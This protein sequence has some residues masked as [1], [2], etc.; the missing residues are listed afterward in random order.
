MPSESSR[1]RGIAKRVH[2]SSW[3][4]SCR[5]P[6]A[7]RVSAAG[8]GVLRISASRYRRLRRNPGVGSGISVVSSGRSGWTSS[9]S[10]KNVASCSRTSSEAPIT[11]T[12]LPSAGVCCTA[13]TS[14]SSSRT[15]TC[16]PGAIS[17]SAADGVGIL[18]PS[19][20]VVREARSRLPRSEV[21]Q[22]V[23]FEERRQRVERVEEQG[24]TGER[25]RADRANGHERVLSAAD[26]ERGM[27]IAEQPIQVER[28]SRRAD[29][30]PQRL[31]LLADAQP[32]AEELDAELVEDVTVE[33]RQGL[34][35]EQ[36]AEPVLA[37]GA[38]GV[39][40]HPADAAGHLVL[41]AA[42][43]ARGQTVGFVDHDERVEA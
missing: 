34:A 19:G 20:P 5:W 27:R 40:Q 22:P 39:H 13:R 9:S 1:T 28:R 11:R 36:P 16:A 18:P 6:T 23:G 8:S 33:A 43:L 21:L 25:E 10:V 30:L 42:H 12:S 29:R 14:H 31:E 7:R 24:A 26:V 4:R 38:G 32:E 15:T 17:G 3:S 2:S 41:V 35:D 37:G